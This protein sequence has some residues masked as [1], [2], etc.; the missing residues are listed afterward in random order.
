[1]NG[2][3]VMSN[4]MNRQQ[5]QG[6]IVMVLIIGWEVRLMVNRGHRCTARRLLQRRNI[7]AQCDKRARTSILS[8]FWQTIR[9]HKLQVESQVTMKIA[10]TGPADN[11]ADEDHSF[12]K[13]PVSG[14]LKTGVDGKI[15]QE[16]EHCG[17]GMWVCRLL[18][19]SRNNLGCNQ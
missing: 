15:W 6:C 14:K 4:N 11:P 5:L 3:T 8:S 12:I 9:P 10:P 7:W 19:T 17:N 1:M 18:I 2:E 16:S 13:Y